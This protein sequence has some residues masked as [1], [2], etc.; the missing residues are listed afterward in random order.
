MYTYMQRE[1]MEIRYIYPT[2][3]VSLNSLAVRAIMKL[4]QGTVSLEW[5]KKTP[6]M[7]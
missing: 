1:I 7:I 3:S 2:I 6:D 5:K 4:K